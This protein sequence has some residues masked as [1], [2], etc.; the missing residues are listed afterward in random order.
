M[1]SNIFRIFRGGQ[2][3][4]YRFEQ[5]RRP[6]Q[7]KMRLWSPPVHMHYL[8]SLSLAME[9]A[10]EK[11]RAQI[12]SIPCSAGTGPPGV[13]A[14]GSSSHQEAAPTCLALISDAADLCKHCYSKLGSV[15]LTSS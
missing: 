8:K 2:Q 12:F 13:T 15:N 3:E 14:G 9:T 10:P 6:E 1:K 7:E 11:T 5:S 4:G